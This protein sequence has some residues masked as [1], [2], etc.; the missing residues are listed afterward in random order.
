MCIQ[1]PVTQPAYSIDYDR[2]IG[3]PLNHS[4]LIQ[5]NC[6]KGTFDNKLKQKKK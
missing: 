3:T 1:K 2:I 5:S 6:S 4:L